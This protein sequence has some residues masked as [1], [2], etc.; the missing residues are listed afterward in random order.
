MTM[1]FVLCMFR[2]EMKPRNLSTLRGFYQTEHP[3]S[4]TIFAKEKNRRMPQRLAKA[5]LTAER[6]HLA[7]DRSRISVHS[8]MIGGRIDLIFP[9]C[10]A[11]CVLC[12][13]RHVRKKR[14]RLADEKP[15]VGEECESTHGGAF[16]VR[17]PNDR[18][19]GKASIQE[20]TRLGHDQGLVEELVLHLQIRKLSP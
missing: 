19:N 5:A 16:R 7:C 15:H 11:V 4:K 3:S 12:E 20:R 14:L 6:S 10:R 9:A 13:L 1:E 17:W 2:R 8:I 18:N